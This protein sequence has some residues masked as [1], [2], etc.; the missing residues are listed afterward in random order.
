[1]VGFWLKVKEVTLQA[2]IATGRAAVITCAVLE[3][4]LRVS[5]GLSEPKFV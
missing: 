3:F 5:V 1:V 2:V 4:L